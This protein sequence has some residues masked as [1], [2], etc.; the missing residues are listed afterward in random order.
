M[1]NMYAYDYM[2][3]DKC[4]QVG[5]PHGKPHCIKTNPQGGIPVQGKPFSWVLR[6]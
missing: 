1:Y 4:W 3:A 6:I 5:I 2:L